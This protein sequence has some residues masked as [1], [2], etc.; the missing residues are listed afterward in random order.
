MRD[1]TLLVPQA[2]NTRL[3]AQKK[4]EKKEEKKKKR[5]KKKMKMFKAKSS[6]KPLISLTDC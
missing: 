2:T 5:K 6:M 1:R 3:K 4:K